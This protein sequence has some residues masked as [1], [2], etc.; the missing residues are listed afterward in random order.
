MLGTDQSKDILIYEDK[1]NPQRLFGVGITEDERFL[2]LYISQRGSN[3]NALYY[4]DLKKR[5]EFKPIMTTFDDDISVVDN[6]GDK[7]IIST[8]RKAP[9][10]KVVLYDPASPEETNWKEILPEKPEPLVSVSMWL[11]ENSLPSI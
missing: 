8:N 11:A 4:R 9:N 7:L 10:Q 3:G 6:I 1:E 2:T 5:T